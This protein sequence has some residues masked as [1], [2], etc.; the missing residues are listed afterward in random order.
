MIEL[1]NLTYSQDDYSDNSRGLFDG[2]SVIE[3]LFGKA[4]GTASANQFLALLLCHNRGFQR[5]GQSNNRT[6][7]G[8]SGL[9]RETCLYFRR[10]YD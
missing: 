8:H 6:I 2:E 1:P 7:M 9:N 5:V 4:R 3:K 10:D